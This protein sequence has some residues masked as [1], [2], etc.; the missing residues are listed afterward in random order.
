M[1][2]P[3]SASPVREAIARKLQKQPKVQVEL[4]VMSQCPFGV[5]AEEAMAPVLKEFGEQ[6]DFQLRFIANPT[7]NGFTSLHGQP[8]VDEDLRQTV[9]AAQFPQQYFDYVVARASDYRNAEWQPAAIAAA[10]AQPP[11]IFFPLLEFI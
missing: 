9:M 3:A 7:G 1:A 5:R 10:P 2:A 6:V 8:E 4:F 11:A